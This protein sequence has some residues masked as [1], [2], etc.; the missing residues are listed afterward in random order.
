M[1]GRFA[2]VLLLTAL[3]LA[4]SEPPT[5]EFHQAQGAVA[6]AR[7]ADAA[8]YAA[9]QLKAAEDALQKYDAAVA[10][11]DYRAALSDALDARDRAYAAAKQASDEKAAA[12]G[13]AETLVAQL[14]SLTK[15]AR[16]RLSGTAGPRL[17]SQAAQR[18]RDALRTASPALQEARSRLDKQDYRSAIA[19]LEPIVQTLQRELQPPATGRRRGR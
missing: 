2:S 8:V 9:D 3:T 6:A 15:T 19:G 5:K 1:L 14:D 12:R 16:A 4:C 11:H 7:A 10:Q 17:S 18:L 13:H